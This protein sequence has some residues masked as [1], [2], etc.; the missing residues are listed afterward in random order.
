MIQQNNGF[1]PVI[2]EGWRMV[3]V[4][5]TDVMMDAGL[6]QGSHDSEWFHVY[7][8]WKDMVTAAPPAPLRTEAEVRAEA[9]REALEEAVAFIAS[10]RNNVPMTGEEAAAAI[11]A[12][13]EKEPT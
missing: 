7:S 8:A 6:Y 11:R 2:P 5:P 12:L 1:A 10:Q 3:P 9:R 4:E 13:I